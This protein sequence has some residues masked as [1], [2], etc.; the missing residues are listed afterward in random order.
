MNVSNLL[1]VS[2]VKL[3]KKLVTVQYPLRGM[4]GSS[5]GAKIKQICLST[6]TY[7]PALNETVRLRLMKLKRPEVDQLKPL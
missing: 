1:S 3:I 7:N 6:G 2:P 4:R 5:I